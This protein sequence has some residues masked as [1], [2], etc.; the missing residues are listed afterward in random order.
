VL[1][2]RSRDLALASARQVEMAREHVA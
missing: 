1:R 2:P